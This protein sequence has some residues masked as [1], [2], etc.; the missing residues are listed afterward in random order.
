VAFFSS[1][2]S[3]VA[4][5]LAQRHGIHTTQFVGGAFL[6]VGAVATS[7]VNTL[8]YMYLTYGVLIGIS[9]ALIYA[10]AIAT[11]PD[12]FTKHVSIATGIA[13][14]GSMIGLIFFSFVLPTLLDEFG[15]RKA[16][17]CVAAIGPLISVSGFSLPKTAPD[18]TCDENVAQQAQEP[19]WKLVKK[20]AFILLSIS[21]VL[22]SLVD[23]VPLFIVVSM[24]VKELSRICNEKCS[25]P[26]IFLAFLSK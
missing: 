17:W 10:P 23:L 25:K 8:N 5:F 20:R 6:T 15:W 21:V 19:W 13:S 22:F 9:G 11:I 4:I 18:N 1:A 12:L 2:V 26:K 14:T 3:P 7:L 24:Q 16:L